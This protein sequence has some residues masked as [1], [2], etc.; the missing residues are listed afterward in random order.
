LNLSDSFAKL[1]VDNMLIPLVSGDIPERLLPIFAGGVLFALS[2]GAKPGVRPIGNGDL[3][4]KLAGRLFL[5]SKSTKIELSNFFLKTYSNYKQ[6]G[7]AA[8]SGVEKMFTAVA[9]A[10]GEAPPPNTPLEELDLS[11][12]VQCTLHSDISNAFNEIKRQ[13]LFD[14]LTGVASR[15]YPG[16]SIKKGD[17]LSTPPLGIANA[18]ITSLYKSVAS[19]KHHANDGTTHDVFSS[20]GLHQG[21]TF[22]SYGF[23]T[24]TFHPIGSALAHDKSVLGTSLADNTCLTGPLKNVWAMYDRLHIVFE[25]LGLRL[26]P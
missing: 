24:G 10:T 12:N 15:D 20:A 4:R 25:G 9:L 8:P 26:N 17:P 6:F 2:K 22:G 7:I 13:A 16:T 1:F 21:C 3:F 18:F 19:F 5:R 23:A 14:A 11:E